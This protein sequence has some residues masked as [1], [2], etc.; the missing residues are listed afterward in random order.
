MRNMEHLIQINHDTHLST[1]NHLQAYR[2]RRVIEYTWTK[3]MMTE[4]L[5]DS[6]WLIPLDSK[7]KQSK[8]FII[9]LRLWIKYFLH[10][11]IILPLLN[12]HIGAAPKSSANCINTKLFK[13]LWHKYCLNKQEIPNECIS[14]YLEKLKVAKPIISPVKPYITKMTRSLLPWSNSFFPTK[15]VS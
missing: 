13:L 3:G 6:W 5:T 8:K 14:C 15:C 4:G 12:T 9:K 1:S 2:T 7:R 10:K 11:V